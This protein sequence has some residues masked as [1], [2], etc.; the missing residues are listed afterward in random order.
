MT[1]SSS[2]YPVLTPDGLW[3]TTRGNADLGAVCMRRIT[4]PRAGV[5]GTAGKDE[6]VYR[7]TTNGN[8]MGEDLENLSDTEYKPQSMFRISHFFFRTELFIMNTACLI[9]LIYVH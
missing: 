4:L 3:R 2:F 7:G 9:F 5:S 1:G 6:Q 8:V